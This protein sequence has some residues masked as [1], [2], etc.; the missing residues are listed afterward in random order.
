MK[1]NNLFTLKKKCFQIAYLALIY[2]LVH[3]LYVK[4]IMRRAKSNFDEFI[5]IDFICF[6]NLVYIDIM[7]IVVF[8]VWIKMFKYIS[9]NKT[10]LQF[11]TTLRRVNKS[12]PLVYNNFFY[13]FLFF[14]LVCKGSFWFCCHVFYCLFGL[15]PVRFVNFW[16]QSS[17]FSSIWCIGYNP[18]A[19]VFG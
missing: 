3:P 9:F 18:N 1:F 19:H 7:G 13:F 10:M 14:N 8:L 6:W 16:F 4:D 2:N 17:R 12:L 15:C 5:S 11:S